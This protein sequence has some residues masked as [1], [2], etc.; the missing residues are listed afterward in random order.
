MQREMIMIV[1]I[2]GGAIREFCDSNPDLTPDEKRRLRSAHT[3][4]DKAMTSF[5]SRLDPDVKKRLR[6]DLNNSTIQV[7]VNREIASR[8]SEKLVKED[9][10]YT[11]AEFVVMDN[12]QAGD[13]CPVEED[14]KSYK[15]CRIHEAMTMMGL[16]P[17]SYEKGKCPYKL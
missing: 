15:K 13:K 10:L 12:C 3:N 6:Y 17:A 4:M 5:V 1:G 7:V 8:S 16:A 14:G 11:L 9:Y 2:N